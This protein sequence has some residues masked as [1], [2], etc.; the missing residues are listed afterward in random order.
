MIYRVSSRECK[1]SSCASSQPTL[2]SIIVVSSSSGLVISGK[3][4]STMTLGP[5]GDVKDTGVAAGAKAPTGSEGSSSLTSAMVTTSV[6]MGR[7]AVRTMSV[8]RAMPV[9]RERA[10]DRR[11]D[12]R[13]TSNVSMVV[14]DV[15]VVV[16]GDG[17]L[18]MEDSDVLRFDRL[19]RLLVKPL[20]PE[21]LTE[22]Y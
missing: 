16:E 8:V 21:K 19:V 14:V 18:L 11:S 13:E 12:V 9:V 6:V 4:G 1:N 17:V 5:S 10:P 20:L 2:P 15:V 22:I 7:S 3:A